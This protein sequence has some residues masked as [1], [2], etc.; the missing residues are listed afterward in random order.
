MTECLG[1]CQRG[2]GGVLGAYVSTAH[3][4]KTSQRAGLASPGGRPGVGAAGGGGRCSH[5]TT[6]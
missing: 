4:S 5:L 1:H 3:I 6:S 2:L